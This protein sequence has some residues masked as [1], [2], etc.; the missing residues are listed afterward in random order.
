MYYDT[1][2][3]EECK[4]CALLHK[5]VRDDRLFLRFL[6]RFAVLS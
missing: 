1:P 5:T 6:V 3:L 4:E 2:S